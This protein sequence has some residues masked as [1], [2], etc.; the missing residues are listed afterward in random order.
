[1]SIEYDVRNAFFAR[2]Q[3]LPAAYF[4]AHRTGDLMSR[5]T[6][7]LSAVR[8]MLGPAVMYAVSTGLTFLIALG[9]MA[10]INRRLTLFALIPLPI[11]TL[12]VRYFGRAIHE[13][14]ETIQ[15]QL[16]DI[17]AVTQ[18]ALAG[19]RIV[20]AYR[21]EGVEL[22]RFRQAN[23]EYVDRNR[24]L[25]RLQG[26]FYPS[27]TFLM[28]VSA[29]LVLWLGGRDVIA[30][31]MSVGDLVAFNAYLM[32]L[33]WPMI[34]FGWVTNLL[35]RGTASWSRMLEVLDEPDGIDDSGVM[36]PQVGPGDLSGSIELRHLTFG[37]SDRIVLD[38]LSVTIA[39]GSTV[40]IVG[41]TGSGKST[42]LA[43]IAR[44]FDPPPGTVFLDGFDV[45]AL[46]LATVRGALG[47]VPQEPFL[48]SDT[49]ANN[50][51]FGRPD[52]TIDTVRSAAAIA[53]LD[54]DVEQFPLG[55]DTPVGE[56]GITLSGGQKQRTAIARAILVDPRILLLDDALSAVDTATEEEILSRLR[57]VMRS[58]TALL[59]SHRISTVKH[60]DRI[61]FLHDGRIVEDGSHE[62]L[63]ARDGLY[64]AL[65][66]QQQLE[67]ELAAS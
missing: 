47:L 30:G 27:M 56:R 25:I 6:N 34:A 31:R 3:R 54:N 63:L 16:S 15:S 24:A 48:F 67:D 46:P 55:Y 17:S 11:V 40:A 43:L 18:E 14:F 53:R 1:R 37:Y 5:A 66:R 49:I 61:L 21:Q 32:M 10:S 23:Q 58:R 26:L 22:E 7:D 50:V 9:L 38:D 35:Q 4:H 64:A 29:L 39:A 2:L 57:E 59:I 20:R 13:R 12:A 42:L 45:R 19:V 44:L 36:Y 62:A 51:R 60:A 41:P 33:S 65:N 28:G 52:A 8:M